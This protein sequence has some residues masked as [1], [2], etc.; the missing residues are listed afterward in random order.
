MSFQREMLNATGKEEII[1]FSS[2]DFKYIIKKRLYDTDHLIIVFS[3]FGSKSDFTYDF[4]KSLSDSCRAAVLWIK[5]D[6]Y[7]NN[8]ATYYVDKFGEKQLEAAVI[9]FI[10]EVQE[11]LN[12][13]TKNCTL[14]GCSKGGASAMYYG[15]KYKFKNIVVTAPTL[16][17]GSYIGGIVPPRRARTSFEF[18]CNNSES[19]K[20]V[21]YYDNLITNAINLD[22]YYNRN[23]YLLSSESDPYHSGQIKPFIGHFSK[24][25]NFNYIESKSTLVRSHQDVTSFNVPLII[26]ILNCLSFN[27]APSFSNRIIES[28]D[29]QKKVSI[30]KEPVLELKKFD[31]DA[32]SR[33][34]L[35]GVYFLRGLECKDYSDLKYTLHLHG[36]K[37]FN[38]K[39]AKGN[40]PDNSKQYYLD[41]FVNYDKA[42]FCSLKYNGLDMSSIPV[43]LYKIEIEINMKSGLSSKNTITHILKESIASANKRYKLLTIDG[44]LHLEVLDPGS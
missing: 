11:F 4:L 43:G 38:I 31:F 21:A 17:I 13:K 20:A 27:M 10:K 30:S 26:S 25:S 34:H 8:H 22:K 44:A 39:L 29:T 41:T 16:K 19:E 42:Y 2:F 6:F 12:I 23:I 37:N 18:I 28:N 5:D 3:G 40:R 32:N 9:K 15:I 14:L 36:S 35:E 33:L 1:R 7:N 24:Y